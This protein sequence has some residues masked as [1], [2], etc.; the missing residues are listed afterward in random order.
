[1]K[2]SLI[3]LAVLTALGAAGFAGINT[4]SAAQADSN[5]E[6]AAVHMETRTF[7]VENMT[8][9]LCPVTVR[10]A[11]EK[12]TGVQS[13]TV[14]FGAKT[15]AVMFDSSIATPEAI[16]QASS[17]AGYPAKLTAQGG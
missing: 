13:V 5:I 12:V 11:M 10:K 3:A 9:A 4:L 6:Q 1:M 17:N 2:R 16:A 7:A 8:C 15:A 14:D